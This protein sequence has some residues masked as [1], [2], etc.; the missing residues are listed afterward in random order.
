MIQR[1]VS[2]ISGPLLDRID[3]HIEVPA[4]KYKELRAPAPSEDS[5]A[6]RQRVIDA[7]NR[8]TERYRAD[9]KTYSNA[10]M[11]PKMIRKYCA[12]TSDGEKLLENAI[13][14][15]GLSARA[16]DRILKVARTIADLDAAE[17]I[18]PRHLSEAIQYRTLDRSYWS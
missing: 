4:V 13:T 11:L 10:Q 6:V 14:R 8:Q 2:K 9:K 16:H 17:N 1:Y 5:A 7:R 15:L 12:I 3:I 18:E